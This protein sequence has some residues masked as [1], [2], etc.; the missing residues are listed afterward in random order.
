MKTQ[1]NN[2]GT[3]CSKI[4][5]VRWYHKNSLGYDPGVNASHTILL[6]GIRCFSAPVAMMQPITARLLRLVHA[7]YNLQ[8]PHDQLLWGG[9]L[10]CYFFL[11]RR[12]EYLLICGRA[13]GYMLKLEDI[14]FFK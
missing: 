6:R 1:G 12:S 7:A 14:R 3:I 10:L 5:A 13:H 11:L 2:Y 9:L 4:C 8:Y